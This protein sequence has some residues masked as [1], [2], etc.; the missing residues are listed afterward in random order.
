MKPVQKFTDEYLARC[1]EMSPDDIVKFLED[2]RCV[3]GEQRTRSRLISMK[4]PENLL[5]VFKTKASLNNVPYQTQIKKLMM[6]WL[7]EQIVETH[8]D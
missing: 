1:S 6:A 3:H 7:H 8:N 4:V 5:A 2:F